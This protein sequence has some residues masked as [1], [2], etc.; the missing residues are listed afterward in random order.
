MHAPRGRQDVLGGDVRAAGG[1][2]PQLLPLG[3]R[4]LLPGPHPHPRRCVHLWCNNAQPNCVYLKCNSSQ[5]KSF[6]VTN[7]QPTGACSRI[8]WLWRCEPTHSR[9]KHIQKQVSKGT[10]ACAVGHTASRAR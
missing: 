7:L 8:H 4:H 5:P 6:Y 2:G 10:D 1:A 3:A 9:L